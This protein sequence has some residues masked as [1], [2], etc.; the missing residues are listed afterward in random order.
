M[1]KRITPELQAYHEALER[2]AERAVE[3]AYEE[4]TDAR[5]AMIRIIRDSYDALHWHKSQRF[6]QRRIPDDDG[7]REL[8]E[9]KDNFQGVSCSFYSDYDA[10][11]WRDKQEEVFPV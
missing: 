6:T 5:M 7:E 4:R 11:Q 1:I 3:V 10:M 2:W 9:V 8:I